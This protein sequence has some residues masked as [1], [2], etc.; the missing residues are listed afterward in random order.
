MVPMDGAT[1]A[2]MIRIPE[3][4]VRK[5]E[6]PFANYT[7]ASPGYFSSVGTP[8]LRGRDFLDT[9]TDHSTP[10]TIINSSMA[11]KFWPGENPIGKQLALGSP[12]YPPMT[13]VGVVPNIKHLSLRDEPGPEMYVP[14]TQKP[15]PSMLIMHFVL[16]CKADPGSLIGSVRA[17]L[18]SLDPDLPIARVTTLEAIVANSIAGQRFSMLLLGAFAAT[19]LLL[20]SCGL[21]GLISYSVGQRTREVGIRVALGAERG[22][23]IGMFLGQGA[24]LVSVGIV[25]GLVAA[26][27]VTHAMAGFLYGVQP[28]DAGTFSCVSL[29]LIAVAL[30]ACY[31][32]ARRATRIDPIVALRHD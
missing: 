15:F 3:R 32:P 24:R 17:S 25:L 29:L 20:A 11:N 5:N 7:I 12:A 10:V 23:V 18:R 14:F 13:I 27:G 4:P 31:V 2:T 28:T 16:R 22:A 1:D 9:D 6:N 26:A 19:S 30:L 8:L 21:Y